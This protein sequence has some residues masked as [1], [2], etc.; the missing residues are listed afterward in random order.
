MA[1]YQSKYE[2]E[3]EALSVLISLKSAESRLR[4]AKGTGRE[5]VHLTYE[6]HELRQGFNR[7]APH[8]RDAVL[9]YY[10]EI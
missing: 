4:E 6:V 3:E 2:S 9:S 8:I 5:F 7:F 10:K 1:E